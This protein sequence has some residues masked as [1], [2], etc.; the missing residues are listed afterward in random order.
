MSQL[1]FPKKFLKMSPQSYWYQHLAGCRWVTFRLAQYHKLVI[2]Y[3]LEKWRRR[4]RLCLHQ[5]AKTVQFHSVRSHQCHHHV[6]RIHVDCRTVRGVLAVDVW[7][8]RPLVNASAVKKL[9]RCT[10]NWRVGRSASP[11]LRTSRTCVCGL[12]YCDPL[13]CFYTT[14]RAVGFKNQCLPPL[15]VLGSRSLRGRQQT[16]HSCLCCRSDSTD[17][18][19]RQRRVHRVHGVRQCM[20]VLTCGMIEAQTAL[21][22]AT[23]TC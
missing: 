15:H 19:G 23:F 4:R 10:P 14:S 9:N 7:W 12:K 22:R 21:F 16:C 5:N 11:R 20:A 8:C 6:R 18:S 2:K 3:S 1:G 17:I 13:Q